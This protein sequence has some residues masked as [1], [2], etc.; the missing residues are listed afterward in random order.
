MNKIHTNFENGIV[1]IAKRGLRCDGTISF[2]DI[3]KNKDNGVLC[4]GKKNHTRIYK[5]LHIRE[6]RRAGI[7]II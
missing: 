1:S 5:N 4:A 2:N 6:N 7:K 3:F